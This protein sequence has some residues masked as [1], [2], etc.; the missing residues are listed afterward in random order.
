MQHSGEPQPCD[1]DGERLDLAGPYRLYPAHCRGKGESADPVEQASQPELLHGASSARRGRDHPHSIDD[2]LC[3]VD[4]AHHVGARAGV[5]TERA[6]DPR[7]FRACQHHAAA[8]QHIRIPHHQA[9]NEHCRLQK[10]RQAQPGHLFSPVPEPVQ[11]S[12]WH[13]EKVQAAHGDLDEQDAAA[14]EVRKEHLE[15][16]I[17]EQ[18]QQEQAHKSA[19]SVQR[20]HCRTRQASDAAVL[21]AH[22]LRE[23]RRERALQC[24]AQAV[25]LYRHCGEQA[26]GH[27]AFD[28]IER[29]A[30]Q[31]AAPRL[32]LDG[33][34]KARH[35][36]PHRVQHPCKPAEKQHHGLRPRQVE[37]L[38]PHHVHHL[39]KLTEKTDQLSVDPVKDLAQ[40]RVGHEIPYKNRRSPPGYFVYLRPPN[41]PFRTSPAAGPVHTMHRMFR[42]A[43]PAAPYPRVSGQLH[44]ILFSHR[45]ATDMAPVRPIHLQNAPLHGRSLPASC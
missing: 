43:A 28:P 29:K 15:H 41:I 2:G 3:R 24:D 23:A 16:G 12:A 4:R 11:V 32:G 22:E 35:Y 7:N 6:R 8:Q 9:C 44:T 26:H 10:S 17:A 20:A 45:S 27:K 30:V 33:V 21:P 31:V 36:K 38:H 5:H 42:S 37:Q 18:D 40:N 25:Q 39:K 19:V 34:F 1:F 14:P 13:A